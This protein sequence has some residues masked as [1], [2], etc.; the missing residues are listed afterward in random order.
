MIFERLTAAIR[1]ARGPGMDG[2]A[3]DESFESVRDCIARVLG[4]VLGEFAFVFW[5]ADARRLWFGRWLSLSLSLSL[6]LYI[7]IYTRTHTHTH[8]QS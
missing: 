4:S 2:G 8:T 3:D 1:E 7:Y 6:S 5:E